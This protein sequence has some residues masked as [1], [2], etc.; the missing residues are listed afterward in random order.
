MHTGLVYLGHNYR[1]FLRWVYKNLPIICML[2]LH[3]AFIKPPPCPA[4]DAFNHLSS[5]AFLAAVPRAMASS[6]SCSKLTH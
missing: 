5:P 1:S 4:F 2:C 6:F 3:Q